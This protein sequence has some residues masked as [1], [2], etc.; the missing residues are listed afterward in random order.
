MRFVFLIKPPLSSVE[1]S[2]DQ[3]HPFNSPPLGCDW[4]VRDVP[5]LTWLDDHPFLIGRLPGCS[6]TR[7]WLSVLA[8]LWDSG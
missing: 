4:L 2:A 8:A 1:K 5:S 6:L 7:D 3:G